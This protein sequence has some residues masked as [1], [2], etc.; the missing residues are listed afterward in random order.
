MDGGE[1]VDLF[2]MGDF[3]HPAGMVLFDTMGP[4]EGVGLVPAAEGVE[5]EVVVVAEGFAE[6]L[7]ELYVFAHAFGAGAGAVSHEPLLTA[8]AHAFYFEAAFAN[9]FEFE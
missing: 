2:G 1:A 4:V 8:E 6:G 3:F 9:V 7:H 5:H